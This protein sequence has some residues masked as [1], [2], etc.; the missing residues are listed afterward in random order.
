[1]ISCFWYSFHFLVSQW[2]IS[3]IWSVNCHSTSIFY[4]PFSIR[5]L[6]SSFYHWF[7]ILPVRVSNL[8]YLRTL[9]TRVIE[10]R[11]CCVRIL[12]NIDKICVSKMSKSYLLWEEEEIVSVLC[13]FVHFLF[14]EK[15]CVILL[16]FVTFSKNL[17]IKM[18]SCVSRR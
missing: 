5:K 17:L 3:A 18:V 7:N 13:Y 9:A 15:I 14:C 12:E 16:C 10:E 6:T 1:M 11:N 8:L 2:F 4:G